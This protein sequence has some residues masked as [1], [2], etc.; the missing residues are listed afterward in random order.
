[1]TRSA[2]FVVALLAVAVFALS[3]D[4]AHIE[5]VG[6]CKLCVLPSFLSLSLSLFLC[7]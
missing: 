5:F 2:I 6:A 7:C 4:A 3:A 1:M